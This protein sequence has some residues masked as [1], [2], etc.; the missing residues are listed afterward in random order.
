MLSTVPF[1]NSGDH[2]TTFDRQSCQF[3]PTKWLRLYILTSLHGLKNRATIL[4]SVCYPLLYLS[5]VIIYLVNVQI[6]WDLNMCFIFVKYE[7]LIYDKFQILS[8]NKKSIFEVC[9][10]K[11]I[12]INWYYTSI[13]IISQDT[14]NWKW[15]YNIGKK[16]LW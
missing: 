10:T 13:F 2:R 16:M 4:R 12:L 14:T 5:A 11:L 7:L 6:Q 3:Y 1:K 8:G 9:I 15:C